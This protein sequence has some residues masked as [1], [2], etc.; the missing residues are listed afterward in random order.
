MQSYIIPHT[1]NINDLLYY[2]I[3]DRNGSIGKDYVNYKEC[4]DKFINND[5][6]EIDNYIIL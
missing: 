6:I 5:P 4:I 1:N 2:L 3:K